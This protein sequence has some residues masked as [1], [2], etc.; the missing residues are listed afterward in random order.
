[1]GSERLQRPLKESEIVF[2]GTA[3]LLSLT[4]GSL[5]LSYSKCR[6][7]EASIKMNKIHHCPLARECLEEAHSVSSPV[8]NVNGCPTLSV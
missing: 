1:M 4:V 7:T 3:A 8:L 5:L 6:K 2:M